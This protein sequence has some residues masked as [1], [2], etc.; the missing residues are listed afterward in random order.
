MILP[1]YTS[2]YL[3]ALSVVIILLNRVQNV[4]TSPLYGMSASY[5]TCISFI[6]VGGRRAEWE[7]GLL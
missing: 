7:L 5:L 6:S 2:I 1:N 4:L 3:G